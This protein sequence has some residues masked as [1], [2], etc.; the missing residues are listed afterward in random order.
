MINLRYHIVSLTAVFLAIGIGVTLGSTFLD[1]ATVENLN[2]QLAS[3]EQ[4]LGE[5][6]EQIDALRSDLD[7][8]EALQSALDEQG[9]SLLSDA[10]GPVPVLVVASEGVDGEDVD[11]AIR[12][13]EVAGAEVQGLWWLSQRFL[14]GDEGDVTDLATALDETSNDPARLRR[15]AVAALGSQLRQRQ[16]AEPDVPFTEEPA[17]DPAPGEVPADPATD[18]AA[19]AIDP[20]TGLPLEPAPDTGAEAGAEDDEPPPLG[21][22]VQA[23]LD[24]GFIT[25]QPV[26]DGPEVPVAPN[27]LRVVLVG[28]SSALPDDVVVGPLLDRIVSDSTEPIGTLVTSALGEGAE[29]SE[30][31]SAVRDDERL[32]STVATVDDLEHF[33][34]W[35]AVVLALED[36][37]EGVV[38]HYG[39]GDGASSL[40]PPLP[41]P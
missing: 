29:V 39:L 2:G 33:Q 13:L 1:R 4:R 25:F 8:S 26:D 9:S 14:L 24:A 18:P 30:I 23:M 17:T 37:A 15:V 12:A 5:R 28:G 11:G 35:I 22:D 38:G 10:L 27:G 32:R 40:L 21:D 34:G 3:L 6:D 36:L 20:A 19:G 41:V 16:R 31:V 7:R